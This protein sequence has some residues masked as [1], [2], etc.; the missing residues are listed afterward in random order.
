M[1]PKINTIYHLYNRGN[2]KSAI[3]LDP[4]D[5][6]YL[7]YLIHHYFN[8]KYFDLIIFCIMPNHF[9]ILVVQKTDSSISKAMH[10]IGTRYPN[11]FNRKYKLTGHLFQDSYKH[12]TI[13][14]FIY[15]RQIIKYIK[16]NPSKLSKKTRKI[17]RVRKNKTLI[18]YYNMYLTYKNDL[19]TD[20]PIVY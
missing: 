11:Y 17:T 10:G 5:R 18:D 2:R 13:D 15:F 14:N 8:N 20:P 3:C 1:K 7:S 6:N 12:R 16:N 9:H 19:S 4:Y